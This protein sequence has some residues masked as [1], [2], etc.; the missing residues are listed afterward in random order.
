MLAKLAGV[1]GPKSLPFFST[2]VLINLDQVEV[3]LR[4]LRGLDNLP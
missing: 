1:H 3:P 4:I 2:T